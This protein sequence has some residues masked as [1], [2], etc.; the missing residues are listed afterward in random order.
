MRLSLNP[1]KS[2][3]LEKATAERR[4]AERHPSPELAAFYWNGDKPRAHD[5]R[6]I[7]FTGLYLKTEQQWLPGAMVLLTLQRKD[8]PESIPDQWIAVHAEVIRQGKDGIALSFIVSDFRDF[9]IRE[10]DLENGANRKE[11]RRFLS[12]LFEDS[13]SR[14]ANLGIASDSSDGNRNKFMN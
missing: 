9:L 8:L 13:K 14:R 2:L 5:I 1:L 7:S 6:D 11:L 3:N 4:R 12:R 10:C